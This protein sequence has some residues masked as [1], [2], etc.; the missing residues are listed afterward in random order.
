MTDISVSSQ[1]SFSTAGA[2]R[3]QTPE[4]QHVIHEAIHLG[5]RDLLTVHTWPELLK[6]ETYRPRLLRKAAK[7]LAPTNER[8]A[9][10]KEQMETDAEMVKAAGQWVVGRLPTHRHEFFAEASERG[11]ASF[12][13]GIGPECAARVAA[14]KANSV[15][16]YPGKWGTETVR[17]RDGSL[18][19]KPI[20]LPDSYAPASNVK[21]VQ[22]YL[23]E[24]IPSII[25]G[26]MFGNGKN[27]GHRHKSSFKSSHPD[28]PNEPELPI[29]LV[30][31]TATALYA[32]INNWAN[33]TLCKGRFTGDSFKDKYEEHVASLDD[34]KKRA[35]NNFHH[36]M[37]T[38]YKKVLPNEYN[39]HDSAEKRNSGPLTTIDLSSLD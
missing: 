10:I 3:K 12:R 9:A 36:V 35:P 39:G 22:T 8:Y 26:V 27:W 23:N 32:A 17:D 38:L 33:G 7:R 31:L 20:W 11:L 19:E 16:V 29:P 30:A 5:E 37:H 6:T 13:L 2:I 14:L 4:M 34:L 25:I 24:A 15:Y 28:H 21:R 1:S 18:I